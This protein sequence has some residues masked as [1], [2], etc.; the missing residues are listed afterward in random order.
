MLRGHDRG[1]VRVGQHV[2]PEVPLIPQHI[3][4][5][6]ADEHDVGSGADRHVHVGV[7]ARPCEPRIDMDH[8]GAAGLRLHY[9]LESYRMALGHVRA[10]D[11]DA[12]GVNQVT[13]KIAGAAAPETS[14]QTGDS[15]GV[16][17]P[18]WVTW[19]SLTYTF[20]PHPTA[21]Y[22][23]TDFTTRSA[24]ATRG[25]SSLVRLLLTAAPSPNRSSPVSWRKAGQEPNHLLA[26]ITAPP[27]HR[28]W[29]R[30]Q[31]IL[32]LY[33]ADSAETHPTRAAFG[34]GRGL[35]GSSTCEDQRNGPL[36]PM[37]AGAGRARRKLLSSAALPG[38]MRSGRARPTWASASARPSRSPTSTRS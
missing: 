5:Q 34:I 15:G 24:T 33:P 16:S 4:D 28:F 26:P 35:P 3:V 14:P 17:N 6:G 31:P 38:T 13:R 27:L 37:A 1:R 36:C 25:R 18:I 11:Q 22:G 19:S 23:H 10:F 29:G 8:R 7:S 20:C 32:G 12:V 21:Q 2:V 30:T 9:P